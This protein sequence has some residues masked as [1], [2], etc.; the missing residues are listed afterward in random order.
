MSISKVFAAAA[1][2]ATF[3]VTTAEAQSLQKG[4]VPAEFPPS[5]YAGRQY[6]D[7]KG[8]VF[9]RAGIDGNVTWVPRVTRSRTV[10]CG[11]QPTFA[12]AA[13]AT[14][15]VAPAPATKRKVAQK[16]VQ[17]VKVARVAEPVASPYKGQAACRGGTAVSQQY[18]GRIG[19]KVRCG[20]QANRFPT[21]ARRDGG[22]GQQ[23]HQSAEPRI[24]PRHV[25]ENQL[26]SAMVRPIP[27]GYKH[28]WDDDRLNP[29]RAHQTRSGKA[30]MDQVWSET[31]PR[32][33]ISREAAG[34]NIETSSGDYV[35]VGSDSSTLTLSTRSKPSGTTSARK[36]SHRYVQAGLFASDASARAA[37]K[38][39]SRRGVSVR[40]GYVTHKNTRYRAVLAGP[41]QTQAQL[42]QAFG[43]VRAAGY[44]NA[45]LRK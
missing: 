18:V 43:Q 36:A 9:I 33:L 17:P 13:P 41:Y 2:A 40:M 27:K 37:V 35:A 5:S 20:P 24:V 10:I 26:A 38:K 45:R 11:F 15:R 1:I 30:M 31:L 25:Y 28:A 8:C 19:Q 6:V 23:Y 12:Q 21:R 34:R 14:P 7:S 3:T 29:N 42:D 44:R 16:T 4:L 39:L 22:Q 32:K